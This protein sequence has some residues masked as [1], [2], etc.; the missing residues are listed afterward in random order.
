MMMQFMRLYVLLTILSHSD[1]SLTEMHDDL[2]KML[3]TPE[4]R[5]DCPEERKFDV[6]K[7]IKS[8]LSSIEGAIIHNIDG[9][10]VETKNGWWLI[11]ASNTQAVLVA[12]CESA[13]KVGL[14]FLKQQIREHLA[15]SNINLPIDLI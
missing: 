8:R 11:R 2:P 6:I 5:I 10:R 7:E 4:L 9:V 15:A 12:R 3:N 13:T 1:K 14:Q